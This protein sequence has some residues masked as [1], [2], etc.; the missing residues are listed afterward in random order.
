MGNSGLGGCTSMWSNLALSCKTFCTLFLA[1]QVRSLSFVC[2][3]PFILPGTRWCVCTY[4][5]VSCIILWFVVPVFCCELYMYFQHCQ[6]YTVICR[7]IIVCIWMRDALIVFYSDSI[8]AFCVW[9]VMFSFIGIAR[10]SVYVCVISCTHVYGRS[11]VCMH[12]FRMYRSCVVCFYCT[13]CYSMYYGNDW[14]ILC[15][16]IVHLS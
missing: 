8:Q 4:M 11:I 12:Y 15:S 2:F 1:G 10:M 9:L 16:C 7:H 14:R 5:F 6:Q 13:V 3:V